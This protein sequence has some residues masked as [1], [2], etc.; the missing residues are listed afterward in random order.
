[1]NAIDPVGSGSFSFGRADG[2]TV[3][4]YSVAIGYM[5]E[6]SGLLSYAEGANTIASGNYSHAEG[7]GSVAS[8]NGSH[9]EGGVTTASGMYSHAE[10][11]NSIASGNFQH[12]QGKNNIADTTSAHIVGNGTSTSDSGRSNAHTLDW[13]G[14]A[15][16]SGDVYVGS[17]SGKNKDEGSVKLAKETDITVKYEGNKLYGLIDGAWQELVIKSQPIRASIQINAYNTAT[18]T[19]PESITS[20]ECVDVYQNGLYLSEGINYTLNTELRV[21][22]L[23]NYGAEVDDVF[24]FVS[25]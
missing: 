7:T 12:V 25:Y 5:V 9:A 4:M 19:I 16:Y 17:T 20:L 21:I 3:G 2:T 23:I 18:I 13:N 1:M 11:A 24:A 14:N 8:L 22:N 10:G 6:A 15:W